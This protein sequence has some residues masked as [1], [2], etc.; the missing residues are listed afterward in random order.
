MARH[1]RSEL[2]AAALVMA[3]R[4]RNPS[5]G[6]IH[7]SARYTRCPAELVPRWGNPRPLLDLLRVIS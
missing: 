2:V 1:L 6:L 3:I 5:A 4:I 7:H